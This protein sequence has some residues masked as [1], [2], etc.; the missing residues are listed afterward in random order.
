MQVGRKLLQVSSGLLQE[1]GIKGSSL[2]GHFLGWGM[3]AIYIGGRF[4]QIFLNIRRSN[5][6]GL[7]PLMFIF[8]IVG[9]A[10][11]VGVN[12]VF[13]TKLEKLGMVKIRPNLPWLVD[14]GGCMF[15]DIFILIQFIYF[16][17][18]KH[19]EKDGKGGGSNAA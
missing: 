3:A 10:T 19:Q 15:L 5:V 18:W 16:R 13:V 17:Y 4:P 2:I 6:E 11:Y 12:D 1:K 9:N 14:A 8:A 7:N